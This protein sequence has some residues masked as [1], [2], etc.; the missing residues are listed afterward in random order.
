MDSTSNPCIIK[1]M[2]IKSIND[3]LIT[4]FYIDASNLYGGLVALLPV[5]SYIDFPSLLACIEADFPVHKIKA[6]GT[7]LPE[8]HSISAARKL[9]IRTQHKFFQ[10]IREANKVE[11]F[12]GYLS[13]TSKK[14]KGTDVKLA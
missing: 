5:G 4:Y 2:N 1:H 6:Y 10:S 12:K 7:Y 14:E 3:N 13:A 9:F 8:E 11:F